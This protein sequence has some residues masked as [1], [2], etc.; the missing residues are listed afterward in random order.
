MK[1]IQG[2]IIALVLGI[3]AA[4]LNWV[5]LTSKAQSVETVDFIA[6]KPGV[7]IGRGERLVQENLVKV[8]IPRT[9]IGN[10]DDFAVRYSELQTV[11]NQNVSRTLRDGALLLRD[12]LKTPPPELKLEKSRTPGEGE[13]VAIWIPVDTR[14]F[15][16][17]LVSPGDLVS[18]LVAAPRGS[19]PTPA[20]SG[21]RPAPTTVGGRSTPTAV[22]GSMEIIGPFK[23]LSLGNRLGSSE[24]MRAA[25]IPQLQE[26]V[27][28]IR[29]RLKNKQLEQKAEKL[30][31]YLRTTNYR[32]VGIM[33][34]PKPN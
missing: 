22:G 19:V 3:L 29:V 21:E 27:M 20:G 9:G 12:D 33:L 17:S 1:N 32:G 26:N 2:L 7:T 23:I 13:D 15:V 30:L 24:V 14:T 25:K 6:V 11:L 34:H 5:Y 4:M 8:G 28:T 10:L 16:P 31:K 18:F